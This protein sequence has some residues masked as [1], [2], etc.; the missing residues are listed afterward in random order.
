ME[1]M[2][3]LSLEEIESV[4]GGAEEA[5]GRCEVYCDMPGCFFSKIF[6]DN[7]EAEVMMAS[8][9][10]ICPNCHNLLKMRWLI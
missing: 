6:S 5:M 4:A 3:A 7:K 1:D 8:N 10:R 2:K 9:R